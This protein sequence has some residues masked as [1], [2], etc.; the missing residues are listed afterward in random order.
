MNNR[1][2]LQSSINKSLSSLYYKASK[3]I[4]KDT[5][6]I[7]TLFKRINFINPK[8]DHIEVIEYIENN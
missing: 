7:F 5:D 6:E 3:M 2:I 1:S 8:I 4:S